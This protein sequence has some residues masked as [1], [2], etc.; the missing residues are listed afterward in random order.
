MTLIVVPARSKCSALICVRFVLQV[1]M[2][3]MQTYSNVGV[4]GVD[5][6]NTQVPFAFRRMF[7]S[8]CNVQDVCSCPVCDLE[9]SLFSQCS[10]LSCRRFKVRTLALAPNVYTLRS[11]WDW[12]L[13][14][15][16][17][18]F[19]LQTCWN[20]LWKCKQTF[21]L[22]AVIFGLLSFIPTRQYPDWEARPN[23]GGAILGIAS[24]FALHDSLT[25]NHIFGFDLFSFCC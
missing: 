1:Q 20:W 21:G 15:P 14:A 25:C 8:R 2:T 12:V 6:N 19:N 7:L 22:I 3:E 24:R 5:S 23:W 4:P 9:K 11:W 16:K 18:Y 17:D 10:C 13:V